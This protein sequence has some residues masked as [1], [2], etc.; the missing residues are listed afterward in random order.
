MSV[1]FFIPFFIGIYVM[2]NTLFLFIVN[3]KFC[4]EIVRQILYEV[5]EDYPIPI[6]KNLIVAE[7]IG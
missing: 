5:F 1:V 4:K 7:D 2:V 6:S 3:P